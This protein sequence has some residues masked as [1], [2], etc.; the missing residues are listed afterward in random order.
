MDDKKFY[1]FI[2]LKVILEIEKSVEN[3][4]LYTICFHSNLCL[5]AKKNFFIKN[6]PSY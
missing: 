5:K 6:C 3:I 2:V 4:Q 1:E